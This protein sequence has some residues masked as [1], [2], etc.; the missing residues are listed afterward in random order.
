VRI[1]DLEI[2]VPLVVEPHD[3]AAIV[4]NIDPAQK[5]LPQPGMGDRGPFVPERA[6][7]VQTKPDGPH[8]LELFGRELHD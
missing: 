7:P 6:G 3:V 4:A 1:L 8:L 2:R 5:G